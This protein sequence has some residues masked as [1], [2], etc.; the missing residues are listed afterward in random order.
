[1]YNIS[2]SV[3]RKEAE[4]ISTQSDVTFESQ[5]PLTNFANPL[6]SDPEMIATADSNP[7]NMHNASMSK[8]GPTPTVT[9]SVESGNV[10]YFQAG[11][12]PPYDMKGMMEEPPPYEAGA[13]ASNRDPYELH[14]AEATPI[15]KHTY[16]QPVNSTRCVADS[17]E[18]GETSTDEN[19]YSLPKEHAPGLPLATLSENLYDEPRR[20]KCVVNS[21]E[22]GETSAAEDPYSWP[23]KLAPSLPL[24][25]QHS[26]NPTY[27]SPPSKQCT[28]SEEESVYENL[29]E[30]KKQPPI[31][32][33]KT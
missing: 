3:F 19:P 30:F 16:S 22:V 7:Q 32:Q 27:D 20:L 23:Q 2:H 8:K 25:C 26:N 21:K 24:A 31:G 11:P 12:P 33:T 10:G 15:S 4:T 6:Y 13:T 29:E 9:L 5:S 28:K 17:K 1:M 14:H 18:V